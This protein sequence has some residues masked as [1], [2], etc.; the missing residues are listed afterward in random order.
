[1]NHITLRL[2]LLVSIPLHLCL[3]YKWPNPQIDEADHFLYDQFGF[4]QNGVF[5]GG[6]PT[7]SH[8]FFGDENSG[9]QNAAEVRP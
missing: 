7:C 4:T 3:A 2:S 5:A 1:M 8:V 6:V 9:R